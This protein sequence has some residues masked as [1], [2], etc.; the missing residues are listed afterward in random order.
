M[1]I[2]Y[3]DTVFLPKTDFPMRAGLK[4]K[5]PEILSYWEGL[6]LYTTLR[7]QS[8]GREKFILHDGP[9]YANGDIHIGHAL[10]KIL[11]DMIVRSQQMMGKDAP[12]VPGWDCHGL[13]IEWKVEERYRAEGKDKDE[14]PVVEFRQECRD[15]ADHWIDVQIPQFKRLGILGNWDNPYKTMTYPAEAQIVR[16]LGKFLESGQLYRGE[17]PVLWSIPERTA[18]ADAEVEYQE[19]KSVTIWVKFPVLRTTNPALDGTSL[20]IWT[21]TTWTIPGNRAMACHDDLAYGIYQVDEV[22]EGSLAKPGER[23]VLADDLAESVQAAAK[24]AIWTRLG[25][26]GPL[27]GT[28][29]A[30]PLR[31]LGFDHDVPVFH[32]DYVTADQGTGLVHIAPGHGVED[33]DLAHLQHGVEVPQIVQ[34]DGTYYDHVPQ[35]A[36]LSVY[37]SEGKD[38]TALGPIL[39]ALIDQG[40]LLAKGK[41]THDYPHSW[42]SKAPLIYRNTAQWFIAMEDEKGPDGLRA[43]ALK[44]ID[45]TAFY[46]PQGQNRLRSMIETRPDWCVSRQRVWGVPL[47]IFMEKATGQPLRDPAVINRIAEV[48]EAEGGDAWFLSPP[49]RFLGSEYSPDAYEQTQDVVEVWFDSGSTHAFVL[50]ARPEELAWPADLYLEGSDQHRGWFHSSLLESCATRDRAPYKG[51]L[52]HG[53]TMDGEGKK[54]SKSIG[55]TVS[56]LA[57]ADK[58]GID[59]LRLWVCTTDYMGDQRLSDDILKKTADIYRRFR[60]TFRYLLGALDGFEYSDDWSIADLPELEQYVCHRLKETEVAVDAALQA[61]DFHEAY[62]QLLKF[63]TSDLSALFFDV[64]KDRV[65]CDGLGSQARVLTLQVMARVLHSLMTRLAPILVFTCEEVWQARTHKA[66]GGAVSDEAGADGNKSSIHLQAFGHMSD[67]CLNPALAEKWSQILEVRKA[68]LAALEIE[69]AEKRL[70]SAM[71]ARVTI[72]APP[73]LYQACGHMDLAELCITSDFELIEGEA[74]NV[75]VSLAK[76]EKCQRCWNIR[77]TLNTAQVCPRCEGVLDG[78][79]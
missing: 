71:E 66:A 72:T 44:A 55:N 11:K 46:P 39:R 62:Q 60:N 73:A 54:M 68:V 70:G 47:P 38:G 61:Y 56:P 6:D 77:P 13:P 64:R 29:C 21:T 79:A 7:T 57:V 17:K 67:L 53:M 10:N 74:L 2:D 45:D 75:T 5:E 22:A 23:L 1:T 37:T 4:D 36:G 15:F 69:R 41:L 16:E 20:V 42:R 26:A 59:I 58:Y 65:Y 52:T 48:F 78:A 31:D 9:P 8:K 12:Y 14:V 43:K 18:L 34:G 35:F 32:G 19:H 33:F 30:H 28:V 24:V 51:V 50:E 49:E 27:S 40:G 76:G 3:K 63:V 25:D